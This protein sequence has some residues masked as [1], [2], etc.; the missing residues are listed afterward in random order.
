MNLT[1]NFTKLHVAALVGC[2]AFLLL[3]A[4]RI[5]AATPGPQPQGFGQD[6]DDWQRPPD[7][8]NDIQRR[9][10]H[11]GIEGARK[12]YENHRR[13]DVNNRDEYRSPDV[14]PPLRKA[15]REGFRR[16]YNVGMSHIMNGPPMQMRA[17]V[18]AWDAPPDE[19][20][21]LRRQGFQD[22]IEGARKD[23]ENHRRPDVENRE[24]YRSPHLPPEQREAY[25]AGFRRGY[26]VGVDHL[27]GGHDRDR[28]HDHY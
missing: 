15:Y 23:F 18:R 13:P 17:P 9:G 12:D 8:W 27:M 2:A 19:F 26:Q 16:G 21:A 24:E 10:F 20:D 3:S 25:R 7:A 6:R 11:D 5:H 14:P 28:D 4:P 22:G 1:K